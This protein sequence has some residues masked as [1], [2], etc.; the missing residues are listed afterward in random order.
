MVKLSEKDLNLAM[1]NQRYWSE[2]S[3]H[4]YQF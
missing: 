2:M 1:E 4:K 3:T